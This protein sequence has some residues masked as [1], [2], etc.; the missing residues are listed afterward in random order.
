[1]LL[2]RLPPSVELETMPASSPLHKIITSAYIALLG[3]IGFNTASQ[4][5]SGR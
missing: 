2:T 3:P 1:M 5:R 4:F